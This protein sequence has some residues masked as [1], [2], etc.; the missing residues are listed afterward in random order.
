[1]NALG[2]R[3]S[4]LLR[5]SRTF[6]TSAFVRDVITAS[7]SSTEK[8]AAEES[9]DVTALDRLL[10]AV[11]ECPTYSFCIPEIDKLN[12]FH[13]DEIQSRLSLVST[14]GPWTIMMLKDCVA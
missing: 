6:R 4:W 7:S 11:S 2:L 8:K 3:P 14:P 5:R 1:M 12:A 13:R 10:K 9:Q